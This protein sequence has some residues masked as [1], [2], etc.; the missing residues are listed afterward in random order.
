M[1]KKFLVWLTLTLVVLAGISHS[2]NQAEIVGS[3]GGS[4]TSTIVVGTTV[5]SNGTNTRVLFD[6]NGAVGEDA[7]L[8]YTKATDILT[9]A[10]DVQAEVFALE[11]SNTSHFL[12]I[13]TTSNLTADRILT[14]VPGDAARTVTINGNPT[15]DD[16]FDQNVKT[17]GAVQHLRIGIGAAADADNKLLI[18]GSA[19]VIQFRLQGHSTQTSSLLVL[20]Q[21]DGTDVLAVAN[22]GDITVGSSTSAST[23]TPRQ[24]NMGGTYADSVASSKA[25]IKWYFDGTNTSGI[26]PSASKTNFFVADGDTI[27]FLY[28]DVSKHTMTKTAITTVGTFSSSRATDL[29]WAV[30][31]G[32]DTACNSTCTSACVF[33]WNLTAGDITGTLLACTDATADACLCAG[34]S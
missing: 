14:L 4:G 5:I 18:D 25:K 28:G 8:T 29:G 31:A 17:T 12:R 11:D 1:D 15:L 30:V 23:A 2:Q 13:L 27:D 32:A 7:G 19:N 22:T 21:S 6:D 3:G 9:V 34:A 26:G 16:W 24:L 10:E 20:E 33:G